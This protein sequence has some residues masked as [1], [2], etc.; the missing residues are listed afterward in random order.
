MRDGVWTVVEPMIVPRSG[1]ALVPLING[2]VAAIGGSGGFDSLTA[3]E[4][5]REGEGW[6]DAAPMPVARTYMAAMALPDGRVFVAGGLFADENGAV[7]TRDEDRWDTVT[8][9]LPFVPDVAMAVGD[10]IM[11]TGADPD[12]FAF[13]R[14]TA[15][16]DPT[17][18][19]ISM[20]PTVPI[21]APLIVPHATGVLAAGGLGEGFAQSRLA[22][23]LMGDEWAPVMDLPQTIFPSPAGQALAGEVLALRSSAYVYDVARDAW[24][25]THRPAVNRD[26]PFMLP[27]AGNRVIVLGEVA[28]E[29]T[30]APEIYQRGCR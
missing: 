28:E 22:W 12:E 24:S 13:A 17:T 11:L 23:R 30:P 29:P 7:Y 25:S 14:R 16:L 1:H 9:G 21:R 2:E 19:E 27:L 10:T 20:G 3:V 15:F 18:L 4:V 8:T 5:W 26:R 6:T